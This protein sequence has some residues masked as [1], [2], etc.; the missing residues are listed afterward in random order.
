LTNMSD[1]DPR[2]ARKN[3]NGPAVILVNPQ[4]G[5]NIGAVARAMLNCGLTD[6]RL[7][8][9]RDPWPNSQANAAAS[10]A[11]SVVDGARLYE[12]TEDAIA[13]MQRVYAATARPRDMVI[14]IMPPRVA[15]HDMHEVIA[16]GSSVGVLFGAERAGLNNDDV[17][18]ADTVIEV[19]LNPKFRSLN[20]AQAALI[21]CY[22][23]FMTPAHDLTGAGDD[24]AVNW[25]KTG[26]TKPVSKAEL[27]NFL[28]RLE[29]ELDGCGFL[30]PLEK[31][32]TMVRTIRNIFQRAGLTDQDVR[33]LHGIVS[34]LIRRRGD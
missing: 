1:E 9:P 13:D 34:G 19:P 33:T 31:R 18:L 7:V 26:D 27:L 11:D 4:L 28:S 20:L 3:G 17:T 14:P 29:A 2:R 5:E 23:W 12:N 25:R 8:C 16:A 22:E 10:G 24:A 6:L 21:V 30:L 15:A 32:P